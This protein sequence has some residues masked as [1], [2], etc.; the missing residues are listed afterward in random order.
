[1]QGPI[2]ENAVNSNRRLRSALKPNELLPSS[3]VMRSRS[4]FNRTPHFFGPRNSGINLVGIR[5]EQYSDGKHS[6]Y[7]FG[8]AS[9]QS[10]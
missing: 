6:H 8:F 1:M 3:S 10:A 2:V 5:S 4:R 9:G 7:R